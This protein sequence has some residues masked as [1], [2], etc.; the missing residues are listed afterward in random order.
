MF[1]MRCGTTVPPESV[2]CPQCGT[3]VEEIRAFME[4]N[5]QG[6][7]PAHVAPAP[8]PYAASTEAPAPAPT[9]P[10]APYSAP[11]PAPAPYAAASAPAPYSPPAPMPAAP[12]A[13]P[14]APKKKSS[15]GLLIGIIAAVV[16]VLLAV[17]GI[18]G[19]N[20]YRSNNYDKA[21][22]MLDAGDYQGAYDAFGKLGSY[23]DSADQQKLAQKWMDYRAAKALYQNKEYEAAL[24]AFKK[25]GD[26]EDSG[27]YIASCGRH[28]SY[29]KAIADYEKGDYKSAHDA[30]LTFIGDKDFPDAKDW[31]YKCS[32][33]E[34]DAL[35]QAGDVY[36]AYMAF[37]AIASYEDS[38]D[39]AAKCTTPKPATSILYF[40]SSYAST[41]S[42][43]TIV[44][45]NAN[46]ASY[47]KVYSGSTLVST[48]WVNAG[49]KL[50]LEL[51]PGVYT[52]KQATGDAWFGEE[53]MF[54]D[55]G[56]Y[57][58]LVFEGG[59]KYFDL[60]DNVEVTLT[61]S[62]QD[63]NTGSD[64]TDRKDF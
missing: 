18:V 8:A 51:A 35:Y 14:I 64:K 25:L 15:K 22:A 42:A 58:V 52:L 60:E 36:G 31:A 33:A 39:R 19:Y 59:L 63:G 26:F 17:G 1:C 23:K 47:F 28:I 54:G 37:M 7:I 29:N 62:V 16:V 44:A 57:E 27:E 45:T 2:S 40:N 50:T 41:R 34:A 30:F 3:T 12:P 10:A 24:E 13:A 32:Y 21:A 48:L 61:L 46:Y 4:Q 5:A 55:E 49:T 20:I 11:A 53:I 9:Q 38:S 6:G 56:Y 43:I